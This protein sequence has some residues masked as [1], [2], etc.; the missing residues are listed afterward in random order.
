MVVSKGQDL[1][2]VPPLGGL[3][4]QQATDTLT[5]AGLAVGTV[6]GNPSGV[7]VG[8]QHQGVDVLPGQQLVRGSLIDI[9]L[10]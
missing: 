7:V 3:T 1:V 10:A 4:L 9:T 6:N 8:A 5:A 2:A